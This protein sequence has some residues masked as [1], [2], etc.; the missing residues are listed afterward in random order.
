MV[1]PGHLAGGYLAA[2]TVLTIGDP[3]LTATQV[4]A[5]LA[6]GTIS[7]DG[8][9]IDLF[10]YYFNQRSKHPSTNPNGHRHYITH[11]PAFWLGLS[12]SIV[13]CGLLADSTFVQYIG[14]VILAGS[15]SHLLLDSIEFGVRW[16]WPFTEKR[17]SLLPGHEVV[18]NQPKGTLSYYWEMITK[19]AFRNVTFYAEIIVTAIA[20]V[21]F[22]S[23]L[24]R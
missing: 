19:T 22:F 13:G 14:W 7:G 10:L 15:W 5:L 12:L 8:P 21:V 16:L 11:T 6:I 17:F 9:D 1:L 24:S 2:L 20:I 3:S 23:S 18:I 4:S